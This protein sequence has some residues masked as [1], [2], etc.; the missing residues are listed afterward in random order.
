MLLG[1]QAALGKFRKLQRPRCL[2]GVRRGGLLLGQGAALGGGLPLCLLLREL[3]FF[4]LAGFVLAAY[5]EQ[6][7]ASPKTQSVM[8]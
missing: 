3:F 4:L 2:Q 8:E 5:Y 7:P 1:L 6:F